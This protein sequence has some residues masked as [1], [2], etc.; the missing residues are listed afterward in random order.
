MF[1]N[2]TIKKQDLRSLITSQKAR[3]DSISFMQK[4]SEGTEFIPRIVS[5]KSQIAL[6]QINGVFTE[7]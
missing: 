5:T 3:G 7:S 4:V 6:T 1:I 2:E